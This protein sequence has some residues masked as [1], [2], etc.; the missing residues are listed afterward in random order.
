[1]ILRDDRILAA[2]PGVPIPPEARVW[3]LAGL[4]LYPG[5]IEPYL[6]LGTNAPVALA[7]TAPIE[8][9]RDL[10]AAGGPHFFGIPGQEKDPGSPGPGYGY[11][12]VHPETRVAA[13]YA[14]DA[15]LVEA[16]REQ[17]FTAAHFV[18]G[19]GL[20][21]GQGAVVA[22]GDRGPNAALLKA[23]ASQVV[24]WQVTNDDVYPDSLMG[25]IAL[26]RQTLLD[27]QHYAADQEDAARRP[28]QRSRPP[29]NTA[30]AALQTVRTGLPVFWEPGSPLMVPRAAQVAAEFQ[31]T[32]GAIVATG[33]EWRRADLMA[34][35][36]LP[37][38][39]P[40]AFPALPK[41][42]AEDAWESIGLDLLRHWD[43]APETPALLRQAG[44]DIAL[45]TH[46]LA[47][48]KEFRR[49]LRAALDRGLTEADALTALTT[50]PATLIG[51][52]DRLGA[53]EP[54][55]LAHLTV[56]EGSYFDPEAKVRAVW[57][58][59]LPIDVSPAPVAGTEPAAAKP[60]KADKPD[61]ADKS[62][63][64][65]SATRELRRQ[66]VARDP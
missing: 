66:R 25:A 59:G 60:D 50:L 29:F 38:I 20:F 39:V 45:T 61:P 28:G 32:R 51:L 43:W 9:G 40:V 31:L 22:L 18:P 55:R 6:S 23:D 15:K 24:A 1:M 64:K 21:R 13:T 62:K 63:A 8:E 17:G 30:L 53:I 37:F 11:R 47:E 33:Q 44:R 2:G 14:P 4:T 46:G 34:A 5:F 19:A 58:D 65:E 42:P 48:R 26:T 16:L 36:P 35:V 49:Q 56:V 3:D 41:L 27:A 12:E 54:G 57:I 10:R 7:P 52:G